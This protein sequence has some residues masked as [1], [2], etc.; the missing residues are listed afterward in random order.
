MQDIRFFG[1]GIS[2][3]IAAWDATTIH[4]PPVRP[5]R[6]GRLSRLR[7]PIHQL[8]RPKLAAPKLA[9]R[10]LP[11]HYQLPHRGRSHAA[12]SIRRSLVPSEAALTKRCSP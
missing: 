5:S 4:H 1:P 3:L 10:R 9:R 6:R 8:L 11:H 7:L 2:W 12:L